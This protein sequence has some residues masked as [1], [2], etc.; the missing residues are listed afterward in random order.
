MALPKNERRERTIDTSPDLDL[1]GQ[2]HL[3]NLHS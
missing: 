1:W 2:L 3:V